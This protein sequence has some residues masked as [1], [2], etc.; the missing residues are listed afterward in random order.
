MY[1][2]SEY[3]CWNFKLLSKK[4]YFLRNAIN[5]NISF[6]LD[7]IIFSFFATCAP[8]PCPMGDQRG[9]KT[10]CTSIKAAY[11]VHKEWGEE[12]VRNFQ[13]N[14]RTE[15]EIRT[16]RYRGPKLAPFI[17]G[18]TQTNPAHEEK[19]G[20]MKLLGNPSTGS[21]DADGKVL[22]LFLSLHRAFRRFTKCHTN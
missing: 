12:E 2:G 17:T 6:L 9:L 10:R 1:L 20:S 16:Q 5:T 19:V 21:P 15:A 13:E 22:L 3:T 18:R 11:V 7:Q 4:S 14:L 8:M